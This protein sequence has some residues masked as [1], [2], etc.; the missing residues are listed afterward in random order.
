MTRSGGLRVIGTLSSHLRLPA[1]YFTPPPDAKG[2]T[3]RPH[4]PKGHFRGGQQF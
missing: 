2:C 3:S 4:S 1:A